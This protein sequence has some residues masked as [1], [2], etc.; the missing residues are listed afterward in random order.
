M[1]IITIIPDMVY[2]AVPNSQV[3]EGMSVM[4]TPIFTIFVC[5]SIA[6]A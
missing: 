1:I 4:R 5:Y 3:K 2:F 6:Q